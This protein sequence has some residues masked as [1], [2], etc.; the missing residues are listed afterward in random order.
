MNQTESKLVDPVGHMHYYTAFPIDSKLL[1]FQQLS[2]ASFSTQ[3]ADHGGISSVFYLLWMK[4]FLSPQLTSPDTLSQAV[5]FSLLHFLHTTRNKTKR[6]KKGRNA[7]KPSAMPSGTYM[8]G[9][10]FSDLF[11]TLTR[12][13]VSAAMAQ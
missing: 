1:F 12:G 3:K 6:K 4:L 13:F 9:S 2:S 5:F 8:R 7:R 11:G 10:C